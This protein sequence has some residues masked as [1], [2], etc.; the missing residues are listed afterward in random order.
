MEKNGIYLD[1]D[2]LRRMSISLTK[3]L[4][5]LEI[6]IYDSAGEQFNIKSPKQLSYILFEKLKLPVI[7][8][9]NRIFYK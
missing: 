7:K 2:F 6:E 1:V 9:Q 4:E 3:D 8:K 5:K